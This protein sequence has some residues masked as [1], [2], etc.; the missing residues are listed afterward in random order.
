[1]F[2]RHISTAFNAALDDNPVVLLIGAR[3]VGKSTLV[4]LIAGEER[5][6]QYL[7]LDDPTILAAAHGNPKGFVEGLTRPVILD[8]IQRAPALL[9]PI[10]QLVDRRRTPGG[11]ILTGS[12]NVLTLPSVSESLAGRMEVLTLHPLSQGEIVGRRE[13]FIDA[14]FAKEFKPPP[15]LP[16]EDRAALF[17]R[18]TTGGYPEAVT[19]KSDARRRAW[20]R[21][22]VTTILQRDIRDLANIEALLDLPRLLALLAARAG[23]LL[24]F[25]EVSRSSGFP[26]TTL[27]RYFGLL[28]TIFL[29]QL[30]P[31]W[32]SGLK[33]RLVKSPKL[34]IG[35]S[36]LLSYLQGLNWERLKLDPTLS[37][38]LAE[39]FVVSE[40]TRQAG[41]SKASVSL[42]HFRTQTD[43]EVDIVL[44]NDAGRVVGLEVKASSSVG[45]NDFKGLRTLSEIAGKK[46]H[47]GVVLYAGN[48]SV[49]FGK[50]LYALP[51]QTL[52]NM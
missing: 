12:A 22:Y 44:E 11:F 35:D 29:V 48:E 38:A 7:T 50:E 43:Q 33:K 37:G 19:R 13:G 32:S 1:V 10:K 28:E 9:P 15:K 42:F 30:L 5:G 31:A 36:G 14:L 3:Q 41:W 18:M 21:S 24:N 16:L 25:S 27:K 49:P 4:Q 20:F 46:F 8:E 26:Q 17:A 39:N 47:R 51:I 34:F 23:G 6:A 40:L 52:W 2:P 45:A